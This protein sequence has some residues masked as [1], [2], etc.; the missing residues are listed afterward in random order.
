MSGLVGSN[1]TLSAR[2]GFQGFVN[3]GI[4]HKTA[5]VMQF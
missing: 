4:K 5:S 2:Q 3:P 1:P